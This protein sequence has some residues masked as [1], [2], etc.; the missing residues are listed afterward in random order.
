MLKLRA[1]LRDN[2]GDDESKG[3][4]HVSHFSH[5]GFLWAN[6]MVKKFEFAFIFNKPDKTYWYVCLFCP[7]FCHIIRIQ[8]NFPVLEKRFSVPLMLQCMKN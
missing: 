7:I 4:T 6:E 1:N 2:Q 8:F 3:Y 5:L